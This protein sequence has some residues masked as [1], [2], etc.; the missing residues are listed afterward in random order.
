MLSG[1]GGTASSGD[2]A[3]MGLSMG[4]TVCM[5]V[6]STGDIFGE[7]RERGIPSTGELGIPGP[8]SF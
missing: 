5:L 3:C 1:R 6:R 7:C 2:M 8:A 4:D